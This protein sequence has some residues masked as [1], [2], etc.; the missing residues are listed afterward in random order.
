MEVNTITN[1]DALSFFRALPD[2]SIDSIITSV[3]YYNLR[4]YNAKGQIGQEATLQDYICALVEVFREGRRC[5]KRAGTFWLNVGDTFTGGGRGGNTDSRIQQ[6][7]RGSLINHRSTLNGLPPKSMMFVP[8]RLAIALQDDG[9]IARMDNVWVK[10]NPFPF[11]G[12]DRAALAH[13]YFFQFS[14][15]GRYYFDWQAIG[16]PV[17]EVS[18]KRYKRGRS[19]EHKNINGAGGQK[20]HTMHRARENAR[21]SERI[22]LEDYY[23]TKNERSGLRTREVLP[24]SLEGEAPEL[25][26]PRSVWTVSVKGFKGAHFATFPPDLVKIPILAGCPPGGVVCDPFMGAGTTAMVAKILGRNFIGSELNPEYAE[27]ARQRLDSDEVA[28]WA[29]RWRGDSD[30]SVRIEAAKAK[31]LR[32]Q[33][34]AHEMVQEY[35]F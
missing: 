16:T 8:H 12:T 28:R 2:N 24:D 13:E 27:I 11:S 21:K 18:K 35:L 17:K 10:P 23:K 3:P 25:A 29:E 31:K 26:R 30:E 1:T 4:D 15:S 5:L 33:A 22:G 20:A 32:E 9:W 19:A 34:A 6:A 7:N 14:K